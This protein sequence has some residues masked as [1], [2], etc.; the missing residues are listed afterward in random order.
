MYH[1]RMEWYELFYTIKQFSMGIKFLVKIGF[2]QGNG[3][4]RLNL[5]FYNSGADS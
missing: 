1:W 3:F 2:V 4:W 5:I